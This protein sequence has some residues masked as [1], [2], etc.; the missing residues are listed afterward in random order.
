MA[1]VSMRRAPRLFI[2][3]LALTACSSEPGPSSASPDGGASLPDGGAS[4]D[5]LRAAFCKSVRACCA[6][7]GSAPEPLADCEGEFD[8]QIPIVAL[9][10]KG[11]LLVDEA[12][13]RACIARI[14][15]QATTCRPPEEVC[16]EAFTG[17][18]AEGSSC[19]RA[20]ECKG[21]ADRPIACA[22]PVAGDAGP[23]PGTC[24]AMPIGK[25]GDACLLSCVKG[26]DCSVTATGASPGE[27][28]LTLC[29]EEDAL[30]CDTT[31]HCASILAD[32]ASCTFAGCAS[33]SYCG[34]VCT[35]RK[36]E[37]SPCA[38]FGECRAGLACTSGSCT[39][40]RFATPKLCSGDFY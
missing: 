30:Y 38:S 27:P 36:G 7:A 10:P 21:T 40:P 5:A 20:D 17:N 39:P 12:K 23:V 15:E 18:V 31:H 2:V 14:D 26:A 37:G 3:L 32:G 8:R 19:D 33:T 6:A 34:A 35:P 13:L 1:Q 4:L 28:V 25:M 22:K 24:R 11:T 9:L 16:W 29:R